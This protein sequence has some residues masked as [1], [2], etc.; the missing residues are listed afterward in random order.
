MAVPMAQTERGDIPSFG[1][2]LRQHRMAGGL[3]QE[4]LAERAG[5]SARGISDLERGARSIPRKDTLAVLLDALSLPPSERSALL[6]AAQRPSV[7]RRS[8]VAG[9]N[10][11]NPVPLP[12]PLTPLVGRD[13]EMAEVT[14]VL[15]RPEVRLLTLTGPGGSGKTRLAIRI[16]GELA[17][18]LADGV[19]F[20]GLASISDPAFVLP[21]VAQALGV[22]EA[23]DRPL[24]E[25][26]VAML[27]ERD[28]LLVL[29][30]VE[31]VVEAAPQV[32]DLLV[33]APTL[34]VLATSRVPLHLA[35]EHRFLVPPLS[36][37]TSSASRSIEDLGQSEAVSLF[38]DRA[39]AV[40]PDFRLTP[41]N[42]EAVAAICARLDG[43]PLAIELAAARVSVL[44]PQALLKRLEHRLA[45][46]TGGARD[47]PER[48]QTMRS[49]ITWS[50]DLLSS[51]EQV[52][53]RR[54]AVFVGG[55]TLEAVEAVAE[56][57]G[58]VGIDILDGLSMLVEESLLRQTGEADGEPRFGMLETIREFGL[59]Q[60]AAGGEEAGVRQRHAGWCI[61]LA[62]GAE[63]ALWGPEQRRW[64]ARLEVEHPNLRAALGWILDGGDYETALQ[65]ASPLAFFWYVH[66]H[67]TEGR[68]W[69]DRALATGS[70]LPEAR[71]KALA[72]A[73]GLAH[74]Q[75]DAVTAVR[76]ADASLALWQ[77][78]GDRGPGLAFA[79]CQRGVAAFWSGD[80]DFAAAVYDE[81]LT[82]FRILDN[83]PWTA[84]LL[85]NLAAVAQSRGD[86]TRARALA[87]EALMLQ[88]EGGNDWG[89]VF[90]LTILGDLAADQGRY[91]EAR[92]HYRDSLVV[93]MEQRDR[94][95]IAE[96]LQG[97]GAV[98]ASTGEAERAA[99][100]LG[101]AAGLRNSIGQSVPWFM[102]ERHD[103][104]VTIARH[105]LG[106]ARFDAAWS[107]GQAAS[108]AAIAE[109]ILD[110][111]APGPP[112]AAGTAGM[113]LSNRKVEVLRLVATG[114]TDAEIADALFVSK[115]TV[116][117]H[118]TNI[119]AKLD[120]A[121]RTEAAAWAVRHGLA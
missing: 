93:A 61:A 50:H 13:R 40:R 25:Q 109:A 45:L 18:E 78:I 21:A 8:A 16:A 5:L 52:L 77:E 118:L 38:V 100:L 73:S 55:C 28:L 49:T 95:Q 2:L 29:D 7:R 102:R 4:A 116:G 17:A 113:G 9:I 46:L 62:E 39:T 97:L 96:A 42:A 27:R 48:Q 43:L 6:A 66:G 65:L 51:E 101:A 60:L 111:P 114:K 82:L 72:V 119:L 26:L 32:A 117:T 30:N 15:R 10:H 1:E 20:A 84:Q 99:R 74:A 24:V 68:G 3:T 85:T 57:E 105:R 75:G 70:G 83:R 98:E 112:P 81:A 67:L 36:L 86:Y 107:A 33:A 58:G 44:P 76:R 14:G 41:A 69:L 89:T 22:R 19:A 79:L 31:Q 47:L 56:L 34:K 87:E 108:E 120:L 106:N 90:S 80:V 63:A 88:R 59:E 110:N 115:R 37:P 104:V 35:A 71:A 54:L 103:R 23:G 11:S 121:N 94:W 92:Q 53:F 91:E 64:F 12:V